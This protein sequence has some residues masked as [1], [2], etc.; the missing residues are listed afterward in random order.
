MPADPL[1][2]RG[3]TPGQAR[4]PRW[5]TTSR[6]LFVP[7]SVDP[8]VPEQRILEQSLRLTGGAVTGWAS[9]RMHGA[10]FF[11][12]LA[13]DGRTELPVPLDCG[14]LHQIRRLPGDGL[15]RDMLYDDEIEVIRGVPYTTPLRATFDAMR[16]ARGYAR[17]SWPST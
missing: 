10:A 9:C 1:G 12:G 13:R 15:V 17:P 3:P 8:S 14:P 11:D 16:Y 6:G 7:A 5:R 2:V 4:G